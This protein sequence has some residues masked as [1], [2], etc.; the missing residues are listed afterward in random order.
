MNLIKESNLVAQVEDF[1]TIGSDLD[2][3]NYGPRYIK[4]SHNVNMIGDFGT[5]KGSYVGE[6]SKISEKPHGKG[7]FIRDNGDLFIQHFSH[8]SRKTTGKYIF[9]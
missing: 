6:W 8:G 9:V 1:L 7:V 2:N 4:F 3:P 5:Y